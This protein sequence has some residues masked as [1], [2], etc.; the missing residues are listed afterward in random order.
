MSGEVSTGCY[1]NK[2]RGHSCC[3]SPSEGWLAGWR[4]AKKKKKGG[5]MQSKAGRPAVKP[6]STLAWDK[7]LLAGQNLSPLCLCLSVSIP[8][9]IRNGDHSPRSK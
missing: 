8:T 6:D 9:K 1:G 3:S 7:D 4:Q 2:R 5:M